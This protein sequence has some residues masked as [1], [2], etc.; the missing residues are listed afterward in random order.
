MELPDIIDD[1]LKQ[2]TEAHA[3]H[4]EAAR[5]HDLREAERHLYK[6]VTLLHAAKLI[7]AAMKRERYVETRRG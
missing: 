6:Y 2:S 3:L 7:D 4:E 1:L 5:S